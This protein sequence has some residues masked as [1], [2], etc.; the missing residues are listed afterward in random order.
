MVVRTLDKFP[1]EK[2][3]ALYQAADV[4]R[5]RLTN[6]HI[7]PI[8]VSQPRNQVNKASSLNFNFNFTV[9][10]SNSMDS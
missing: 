6:W 2:K 5:G 4:I 10:Q 1:S 3:Q 8:N 7:A 9:V